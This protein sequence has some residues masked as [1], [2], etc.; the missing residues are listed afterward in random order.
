MRMVAVFSTL[1]IGCIADVNIDVDG[2]GDGL[3]DSDEIALGSDPAKTDSDDDGFDDGV[4]FDAN[5]N[6]ADAADK[7]YQA[8][9]PINSCR[10]DLTA[11]GTEPGDVIE[12]Y[13]MVDQFGETVRVH[14]FCNQV[15]MLVGA[16]TT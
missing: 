4:E 11:S 9:W 7:P 10:N 16:G 8:G 13:A 14:D 6:P 2:D 15:V 12:N 3:L 5:T 1:L